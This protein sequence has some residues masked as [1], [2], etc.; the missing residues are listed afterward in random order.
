MYKTQFLFAAVLFISTAAF[1][2]DVTS[3]YS[4]VYSDSDGTASVWN[5]YTNCEL[6]DE[7]KNIIFDYELNYNELKS[8]H[9]EIN[10]EAHNVIFSSSIK[11]PNCELKGCFGVFDTSEIQI[12]I[13]KKFASDGSHGLYFGFE[14]LLNFYD[15][16]IKPFYYYGNIDFSDGDM[17][18]F[19]GHPSGWKSMIFG[20]DFI[21]KQNFLQL[22]YLPL[23]F[24]ILTNDSKEHLFDSKN[25]L[26][27]LLYARDFSFY[28]GEVK[29]HFNPFT[30]YYLVKGKTN[31]ILTRENQ[32]YLYFVFDYFNVSA[33]YNIHTILLGSNAYLVY[34]AWKINFDS[35]IVFLPYESADINTSWKKLDKLAPWQEKLVWDSLDMKKEDSSQIN[36]DKLDKAGLFI[37]NLGAEFYFLQNHGLFSVNKKIFIPFSLNSSSNTD[38]NSSENQI[39]PDMLKSFL[40]SGI[41]VGLSIRF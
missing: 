16:K 9:K 39:N 21:Y 29:F 34:K 12:D 41:T 28:V 10:L 17:A 27:G 32:P 19:M 31:G 23:S 22:I 5:F 33:D 38:V 30:A 37:F 13:E 14:T 20:S 15:F 2:L 24:D 26:T 4:H 40:L 18:Y 25:F 1:S 8:T 3:N 7:S 35:T 11:T 36:F 6:R